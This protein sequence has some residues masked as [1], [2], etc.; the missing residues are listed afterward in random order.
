MGGT[1][2]DQQGSTWTL[3][4]DKLDLYGLEPEQLGVLNPL[5]VMVLV[6]PPA[7]HACARSRWLAS[8]HTPSCCLSVL[9]QI[10]LFDRV[11][12]PCCRRC[13]PRFQPTPLRRMA[14]G[15]LL[16]GTSFVAAAMCVQLL[17]AVECVD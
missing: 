1:G 9:A 5:L 15:M 12:L 6:R 7:P 3:Q 8:D 17:C 10:P 2:F 4:A 13:P 11:V 14:T 16:A